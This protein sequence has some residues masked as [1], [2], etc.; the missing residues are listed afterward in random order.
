MGL[1]FVLVAGG[2]CVIHWNVEGRWIR[3]QHIEHVP[4]SVCSA[5]PSSSRLTRTAQRILADRGFPLATLLNLHTLQRTETLQVQVRVEEGPPVYLQEIRVRPPFPYLQRALRPLKGNLFRLRALEERWSPLD[6]MGLL[7]GVAW[8]LYPVAS[9]YGLEVE[10][11]PRSLRI[12]DGWVQ[13]GSG[14]TSGSVQGTWINPGGTGREIQLNVSSIA[15]EETRARFRWMDPLGL[16][17]YWR[18]LWRI[19]GGIRP[20]EDRAW[21]GVGLGISAPVWRG[22]SVLSLVY[23]VEQDSGWWRGVLQ[24]QTTWLKLSSFVLSDRRAGMRLRMRW[25][26]LPARMYLIL[27]EGVEL[28]TSDALPLGGSEGLRGYPENLPRW[29][30]GVLFQFS[31]QRGWWGVIADLAHTDRTD[32]WL[33]SPGVRIGTPNAGVIFARPATAWRETRVLLDAKVR[34]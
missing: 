29:R 3:L 5:S 18:V 11:H 4:V 26:H 13:M 10:A 27:Q 1:I 15:T 33:W 24:Y 17:P 16:P 31:Y 7:D 9:G 19:N 30:R 8:S 23:E 28:P 21:G 25:E 22:N 20:R 32:G 14:G 6:Q 2:S 34:Y 12:L